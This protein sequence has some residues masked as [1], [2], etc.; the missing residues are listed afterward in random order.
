M[1]L[2][3]LSVGAAML[4]VGVVL[5]IRWARGTGPDRPEV[6]GLGRTESMLVGAL[7]CSVGLLLTAL[8]AT[9]TICGRLGVLG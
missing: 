3:P 7:L 9:G 6:A 1:C 8:G 4:V 2:L 5:L